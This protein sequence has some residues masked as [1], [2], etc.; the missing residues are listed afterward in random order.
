MRL[1][2]KGCGRP[3][4][5]RGWCSSH[6]YQQRERQ[7]AYGRWEPVWVDAEPVRA[8]VQALR[9]AGMGSRRV[10]ELAAV[11]RTR[12]SALLNGRPGRSTGP[13]RRMHRDLAARILAV[14]LPDAPRRGAAAGARVP[15]VGTTRRLQALVAIG[16]SQSDL[17]SRLGIAVTNSTGL[18]T[19]TRTSVTAATARHVD[20]LFS[21][22][23][24]TPGGNDRARVRARRRGWAP[25]LAWDEDTIDDPAAQPDTAAAK[26]MSRAGEYLELRALG[27]TDRDILHRWAI[28]VQSLV[29]LLRR[30]G[31]PQSVELQAMLRDRRTGVAS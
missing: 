21:E 7:I 10:A 14:P 31:I 9:A 16:W 29:T 8:H 18:F 28:Q 15:A 12:I 20:A 25:P 4:Q 19:G 5:R 30:A 22:L 11:D 17:C 6:Y 3:A 26:R 2:S 13:L 23:Q 1:C 27:Y 24:L